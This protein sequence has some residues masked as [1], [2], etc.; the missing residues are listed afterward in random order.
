MSWEDPSAGGWENPSGGG[1]GG[2][3]S[4]FSTTFLFGAIGIF[5]AALW[6][7]WPSS[8]SDP[9]WSTSD[10]LAPFQVP[11]I[12]G[13]PAH[14]T[15]LSVTISGNRSVAINVIVTEHGGAGTDAYVSFS[16]GADDQTQTWDG[17]V[18]VTSPVIHMVPHAVGIVGVSYA[19]TMIWSA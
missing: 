4:S 17:D 18:T 6:L 3:G 2:G 13:S 10:N 5:G 12:D 15:G 9:Y 8:V 19:V 1:G 11:K 14:L 7:G 16:A